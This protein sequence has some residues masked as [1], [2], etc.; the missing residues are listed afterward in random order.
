MTA[1]AVSYVMLVLFDFD[2][3]SQLV[4][5]PDYGFSCLFARHAAV[6]ARVLVHCGVV[7]HHADN[8]QVVPYAHL[9]V[10][11]V[12][13]GS[14]FY[15]A[16]AE[17]FIDVSVRN[18]GNFTV[19]KRQIDGLTD[20]RRIAFVGR[21]HRDCGIAQHGFGT[22]GRNDD[23]LVGIGHRILKVPKMSFFGFVLHFRVGNRRFAIGAPVD[24]PVALINKAFFVHI[25]ENFPYGFT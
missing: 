10:V 7:V 14:N 24:N 20:K 23:V 13:R 18:D 4:E 15:R 3:K 22:G 1:V 6:F 16:G 2:Q 12:V 17:R 25:D 5:I 9:E 11:G 8:G 19:G 21:I